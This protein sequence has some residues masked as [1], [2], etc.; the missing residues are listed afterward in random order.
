MERADKGLAFMLQYENVAWYDSG[1]VRI[2][3]RRVYPRKVEFVVCRTHQE[4]AQAITDMVTQSAG[5]YTAAAMGMALAAHECRNMASDKQLEYLANA[6]YTISH[7]RPTTVARMTLIVEGSLGAAKQAILEGKDVAQAIVTKLTELGVDL[8]KSTYYQQMVAASKLP[9]YLPELKAAIPE[10]A[11]A[12]LPVINFSFLGI[13]LSAIPSFKFWTITTLP[14]LGLFLVP[15]VSGAS[16]WFSMWISQKLNASVSTNAKGEKDAMADTA[17]GTMKGMMLT[18]PLISIYIG[19]TMP[20]AISVYWVAQALVTVLQEL[21]LT[22]HY[23][24]VY[25]AEDAIKQQKAAEAAALEA[26]KERVRAERRAANPDGIVDNTSKKKLKSREKAERGPAIEGKLTPEE[27]EALR[28]KKARSGDP[29]RPY[30]RG[31]AYAPSRYAKD[32]T[33][34]IFEETEMP[35]APEAPQDGA[36]APLQD[37]AAKALSAEAAQEASSEAPQAEQ[38]VA[39]DAAEQDADAP[40]E[41]NQEETG[42]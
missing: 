7:A 40:A 23:R 5:P 35:E 39:A 6:A 33:E 28:Q 14:A 4:V 8:G 36:D 10:L 11:N 16:N 24:K 34:R 22:K 31:R 17:A 27:R 26:E 30:S 29:D 12:T 15:I 25:D 18:M 37:E 20:A 9:Q 13:D 21:I 41:T 2:L 38:A 32:G 19:F 42:A 1:E 3:D